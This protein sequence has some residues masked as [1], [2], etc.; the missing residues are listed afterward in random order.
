VNAG[1]AADK[2]PRSASAAATSSEAPMTCF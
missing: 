1:W 2:D